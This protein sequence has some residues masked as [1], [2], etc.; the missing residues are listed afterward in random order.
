MTIKDFMTDD[1]RACDEQFAQLENIVDQGNFDGAKIMWEE[2]HNHM[3]KH[4]E[5]EEKVMFPQFSA[6][7]GGHCDPTQVMIMEHEQMRTIFSQMDEALK[8][9]D[10]DNFLGASE[11]LLFIIQQHN[12][13]EEQ[14][15]YTMAD[16]ALDSTKI[17]DE[18]KQI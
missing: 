4:F 11:T 3:L 8:N 1:H 15:M 12:M 14:M 5:M 13:K 10:K 9:N 6:S 16:D 17:I 7:G 2:F 18:M